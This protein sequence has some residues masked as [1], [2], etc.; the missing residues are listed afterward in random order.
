MHSLRSLLA[1]IVWAV[2]WRLEALGGALDRW[3]CYLEY[4]APCPTCGAP[5]TLIEL[6]HG[7][8]IRH[9]RACEDEGNG[10]V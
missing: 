2:A 3:G 8:V 5:M 7:E 1:G 6:R 10:G 4:G 9:C